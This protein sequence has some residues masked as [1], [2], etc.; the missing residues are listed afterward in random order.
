MPEINF[1]PNLLADNSAAALENKTQILPSGDSKKTPDFSAILSDK[2][3]EELKKILSDNS[4]DP[5]LLLYLLSLFPQAPQTPLDLTKLNPGLDI[6]SLA[7]GEEN[8]QETLMKLF[9]LLTEG[10]LAGQSSS[11]TALEEKIVTVRELLKNLSSEDFKA[12]ENNYKLETPSLEENLFSKEMISLQDAPERLLKDLLAIVNQETTEAAPKVVEQSQGLPRL[13]EALKSS[14]SDSLPDKNDTIGLKAIPQEPGGAMQ[15]MKMPLAGEA[16]SGVFADNLN[17]ADYVSQIIQNIHTNIKDKIH[18]AYIQLK[19]EYLGKAFLK[20][21]VQD[22]LVSIRLEVTNDIVRESLQSRFSELRNSLEEKGFFIDNFSIM[23]NLDAQGY[24]NPQALEGMQPENSFAGFLMNSAEE[25]GV[26][27]SV[28]Q[29][30]G[31]T[32]LD[33]FLG[34]SE[35]SYLV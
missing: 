9:A 31:L 13:F 3:S 15:M 21:K 30:L 24:R 33:Y 1:L 32:E 4:L 19:P 7:L 12:L 23:M 16:N 34:T 26:I 35:I 6:P 2:F 25:S 18:E 11:P 5:K 22:N 28:E 17:K 8:T 10:A 14:L 27:E 20:I 29:R